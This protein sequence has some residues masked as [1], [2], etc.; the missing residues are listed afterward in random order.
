MN[1]SPRAHEIQHG[2]NATAMD[3]EQSPLVEKIENMVQIVA[4][5]R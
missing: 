5:S 2:F 1:T 4:G 3:I